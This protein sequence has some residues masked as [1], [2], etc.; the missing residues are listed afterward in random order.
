MKIRDFIYLDKERMYSLYSQVFKGISD[1]ILTETKSG[2]STVNL[3]TRKISS[4]QATLSGEE[5]FKEIENKIMYDNLYTKLEEKLEKIIKVVNNEYDLSQINELNNSFIVKVIGIPYV[6]DYN[7]LDEFMTK[8]NKLGLVIAKSIYRDLEESEKKKTNAKKIQESEELSNDE[9]LL[10][11]LKFV[12]EFFNKNSLEV[13]MVPEIPESNLLF[14][15]TL[16]RESLKI[17][18]ERLRLLYSNEP[19]VNWTMVGQLT[20]IENKNKRNLSIKGET[21]IFDSFLNV[22]MTSNQIEKDFTESRIFNKFHIAPIAI[23]VETELEI[24]ID[25]E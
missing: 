25:E 14:K 1:N 21:S 19:N 9:E 23:Y 15:G 7:R 4:K 12:S 6:N 3:A 17:E 18:E 10:K 16:Q 2:T 22:I 13:I 24:D 5:T 8:F 11:D 20:Y